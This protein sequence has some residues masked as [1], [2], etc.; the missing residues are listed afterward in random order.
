M[1]DRY[2]VIGDPVAHSLSPRIH[3]QFARQTGQ[4]LSYD[5]VE[6]EPDVLPVALQ[7]LHEQGYRGLNATLPHKVAVM[8]L[9]EA[10]SERAQRAGAVN[11][12]IR[13]D[14]SWRGDNTDGE[15]FISDLHRLDYG[16]SGRRVLVLGAGGAVRGILEPLL[17]AAPAELVVSGRSPWK[18]EALAEQFRPLGTIRPSTHLA[19]KG[20]RF[21]LII[22]ATS[23]GHGGEAPRLPGQLLADGGD[24]YDLSYGKAFAPFR[25]W[26]ESQGA[27]RI[28]D[29]LGMLVGQAAAA[30]E[31][32]RGVRPDTAPVI[33]ALRQG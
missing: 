1:T 13:T 29:G 15:G 21:D 2:A 4:A 9:C 18:P 16:V 17:A 14:S 22:N 30:F 28:A 20:D 8:A 12:L 19:L 10:V 26:A 3:A 31:L 7:A 5:A 33:A 6:V 11:T 25:A 23:A 32:W 27:A 24:C